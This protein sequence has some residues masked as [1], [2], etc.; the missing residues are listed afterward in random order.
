LHLRGPNGAKDE[1]LLAVTT[2]NLRKSA[3]FIPLPAPNFVA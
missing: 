2:Q 3:E 1:F